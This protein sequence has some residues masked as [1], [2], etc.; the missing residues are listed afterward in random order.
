MSDWFTETAMPGKG[1]RKPPNWS[2]QNGIAIPANAQVWTQIA[3]PRAGRDKILVRNLGPNPVQIGSSAQPQGWNTVA[4]G[5]EYSLE[6]ESEVWALSVLGTTLETSETWWPI[7]AAQ[8]GGDMGP[9]PDIS[10]VV[11]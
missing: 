9:L 3:G 7:S 4:V 8:G 11:H 2:P 10:K 6:S 5:D 1:P